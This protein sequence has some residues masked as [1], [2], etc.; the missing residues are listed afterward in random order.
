M[1]GRGKVR[2]IRAY[3]NFARRIRFYP[4][5]NE[6]AATNKAEMPANSAARRFHFAEYFSAAIIS[7]GVLRKPPQVLSAVGTFPAAEM[8]QNIAATR[9]EKAA[10]P[11]KAK[12]IIVA[13]MVFCLASEGWA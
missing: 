12:L 6:A 13:L 10:P 11:F 1:Q 4:I 7:S 3:G 5:C 2:I 8:N 9:A